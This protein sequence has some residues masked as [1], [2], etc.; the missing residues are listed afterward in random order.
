M[1][2]NIRLAILAAVILG[3]TPFVSAQQ[4][5]AL[6]APS[7]TVVGS[8]E[9]RGEPDM[10]EISIG[11]V[12]EAESAA[13]AVKQNNQAMEQ[14]FDALDRHDIAKKDIQTGSFNISPQRQNEPE[15]RQITGYLVTNQ[16]RIRIRQISALGDILDAVVQ[17]GANQIHGVNFS[18][19]DPTKLLDEACRKAMA[20]ARRKATLYA[21]EADAKLGK[22]L[23]IEAGDRAPRPVMRRGVQMFGEAAVPISPGEQTLSARVTVTYALAGQTQADR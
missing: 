4:T 2:I 20:D 16:V 10:A 23:L 11:V 22:V 14:L 12:T 5:D 13:E 9:V 3:A 19:Q 21:S 17:Q 1:A 15:R 7:V 8:A 6:L 18:I